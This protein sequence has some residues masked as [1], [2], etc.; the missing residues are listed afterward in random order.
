MRLPTTHR[1]RAARVLGAAI[2]A[3]FTI[4]ACQD[5][6]GTSDTTRPI[7]RTADNHGSFPQSTGIYRIPYANGTAL[8]V[9]RDHHIHTPPNRIDMSAGQGAQV[10]AAATGVIRAIIDYNGNSPNAGDG[11]GMDGLAQNDALEHSCG[12]NLPGNTV[13]GQCSDYNNYVWVEHANGEFT[14]YTHLGTGTV[15]LAPPNGFGWSIGDTVKVGQVLGLESDIGQA[16]A[17]DGVSPAFHLHYEVAAS[18][19]GLPMLWDSLGGFI[20]N[21][22]NLVPVTCDIPNNLYATNGAYVA[23][24]CLNNLPPIANAGG[25]YEFDEGEQALLDGTG[26]SDPEGLPLTYIWLPNT[27][28]GSPSLATPVFRAG[29]NGVS[30][31]TLWVFDQVESLE[32]SSSTTITVNNV[33]PSVVIDPGQ[34]TVIDEGGTITVK[35]DFT[36]PGWLDTHTATI[37]WGTPPGHPGNEISAASIQILAEGGPG[38]SRVGRVSGTYRYGDNDGGAGYTITVTVTDDDGAE[39]SASFAVTVNNRTPGTGINPAGAINLNGTPTI[40]IDAGQSVDFESSTQDAGSDDL[41]LAW[42]W[43]DGSSVSRVSLVNAPAL[44]PALSPTVEAR[45]EL[46][47]R[48]HAFGVAC[49]YTV[50]F[51]ASDDD[52]GLLEA[53]IDVLVTGTSDKVRSSGYWSVEYRQL[54][55]PDYTTEQLAC[56]LTIVSHVS[57]VFG[58]VRALAGLSDAA[59]VLKQG[60]VSSGDDFRLDVALLE[61]WLNFATGAF[62]LDQVVGGN[63]NV[64]ATTFHNLMKAAETLRTDP[65]RTAAQLQEMRARLNT[66]NSGA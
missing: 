44:D 36:E 48:T 57:T 9:S 13:V 29:D 63:G 38:V 17:G 62:S 16:T 39:A 52:G 24:A 43:G 59:N 32:S 50:S 60:E 12:N 37:D 46:D 35:A 1:T 5:P 51:T 55:S 3:A 49:M 6:T 45:D 58:E 28:L 8:G 10:V 34:I 19:D 56:F 65:N 23:A 21:G 26:S 14:K 20:Q 27:N 66:L 22:V 2:L 61:S 40:V 15:R 11:V 64:P 18:N 54:K 4:V 31:V 53:T 41:T 47:Q 25:P 33:P 30:N 42:N 7:A